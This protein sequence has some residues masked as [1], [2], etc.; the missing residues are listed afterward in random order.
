[1][2]EVSALHCSSENLRLNCTIRSEGGFRSGIGTGGV[3]NV[4]LLDPFLLVGASIYKMSY[5]FH[6]TVLVGPE[7][8]RFENAKWATGF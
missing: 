6:S 7:G 1:M 2:R 8:A 3:E 4:I 5:M